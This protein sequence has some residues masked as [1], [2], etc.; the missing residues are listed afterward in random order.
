MSQ[1]DVAV[2]G[3]EEISH[4]VKYQGLP[5]PRGQLIDQRGAIGVTNIPIHLKPGTKPLDLIEPVVRAVIRK[6]C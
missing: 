6:D 3:P 5:D 1:H 2:G 4:K